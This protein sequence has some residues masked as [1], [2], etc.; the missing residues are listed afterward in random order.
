MS[1]AAITDEAVRRAL[2]ASGVRPLRVTHLGEGYSASAY[3]LSMRGAADLVLRVPRRPIERSSQLL[4]R[5][6]RL[7][8]GLA[9]YDLGIAI[10]RDMREVRDGRTFLGTLHRS[11][12]GAPFPMG[13]RGAARERLC[14]GIGCYLAALHA[15]PIEVAERAGLVSVDLWQDVYRDLI[16]QTLD[17]V[18][19]ATRTWLAATARAFA[20]RGTGAAPRVL[21]HGDLS[22][23]HLF[24]DA[25]GH[26]LGA[27][28]YGEARIADPALDFAGVLNNLHWSD[29]ERVWVAYRAAGGVVDADAARRARFYIA[30]VPLFRVLFGEAAEGSA[31]RLGGVRQLAARAAAATRRGG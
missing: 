26:L 17:H 25:Q 18:G 24:G 15:V 31:E 16:A 28:D 4:R 6:A 9:S 13:L 10:P 29:L 22:R 2:D 27:I 5:E 7:L 21:V 8:R 11:V 1:G 30:V 3:L 23:N 14:D 12:E 19:P 20:R